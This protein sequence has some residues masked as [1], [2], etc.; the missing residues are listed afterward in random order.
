M[1][2]EYEIK[3]KLVQKQWLQLRIKSL[4]GYN[5]ETCYLVCREKGGN[6]Y[7]GG[8]ITFL[9]GGENLMN[10]LNWRINPTD[11]VTSNFG[12]YYQFVH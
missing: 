8:M 12:Y 1:L 2:K 9:T 11:E 3:S 10:Y 7:L 6:E 4:L 5:F